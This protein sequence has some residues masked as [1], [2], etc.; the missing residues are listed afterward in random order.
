M[1]NNFVLNKELQGIFVG[2]AISACHD[3]ARCALVVDA[4]VGVGSF[5]T[6]TVHRLLFTYPY[7]YSAK[8]ARNGHFCRSLMVAH[9]FRLCLHPGGMLR[10]QSLHLPR[11]G[12]GSAL[13]AGKVYLGNRQTH[14]TILNT[15]EGGAGA[16]TSAFFVPIT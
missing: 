16:I 15:F 14:F 13:S 11:Q 4:G 12:L 9:E 2:A 6:R 7:C 8:L 10:V 5:I 1:L 3:T